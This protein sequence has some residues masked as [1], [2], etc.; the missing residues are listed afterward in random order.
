[1]YLNLGWYTKTK[2]LALNKIK[3]K[4]FIWIIIEM[5]RRGKKPHWRTAPLKME[6]HDRANIDKL[7]LSLHLKIMPGDLD[8]QM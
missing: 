1:M 3:I 7:I 6:N 8:K 4:V 5:W 2:P